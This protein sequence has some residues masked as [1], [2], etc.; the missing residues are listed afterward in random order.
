[1]TC[2]TTTGTSLATPWSRPAACAVANGV[3]ARLCRGREHADARDARSRWE[4]VPQVPFADRSGPSWPLAGG[5][6]VVQACH[7]E[8]HEGQSHRNEQDREQIGND[9]CHACA[10]TRLKPTHAWSPWNTAPDPTLRWSPEEGTILQGRAAPRFGWFVKVLRRNTLT[11]YPNRG[12]SPSG[13][14]A[15]TSK[16]LRSSVSAGQEPFCGGGRYWV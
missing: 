9:R 10:G 14:A 12:E 6:V 16:R 7:D 11:N 1:M 5:H 2:S 13:R 3:R 15:I 8:Q 4:A